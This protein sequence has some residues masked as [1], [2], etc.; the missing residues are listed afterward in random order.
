MGFPIWDLLHCFFPVIGEP[1]IPRSLT[2]VGSTGFGLV[3][4]A[5]LSRSCSCDRVIPVQR[6]GKKGLVS[7]QP[8]E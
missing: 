1:R 2:L 6:W 3:A 8:E 4:W 7:N 5:E